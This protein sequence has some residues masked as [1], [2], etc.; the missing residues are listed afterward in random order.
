MA[1]Y[2]DIKTQKFAF[3]INQLLLALYYTNKEDSYQVF[4]TIY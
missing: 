3:A 4:M 2:L 1:T